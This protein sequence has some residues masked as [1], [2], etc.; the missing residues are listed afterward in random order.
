MLLNGTWRQEEREYDTLAGNHIWL[1]SGGVAH[2]QGVGMLL[3]RGWASNI[4][5][6][7]A[8]GPRLGFLDLDANGN[9]LRIIVAYMPHSGY[10]DTVVQKM[11]DSLSKSVSD[12]R[13]RGREIYIAGDWNAE[14]AGLTVDVLGSVGKY[15]N[16]EE[17]HRGKWLKRW[18]AEEGMFLV[19]T[20]FKKRLGQ[21][22]DATCKHKRFVK[23]L[24]TCKYVNMDSDHRAVYIDI[25]LHSVRRKKKLKKLSRENGFEIMTSP[26]CTSRR[27]TC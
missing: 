6:W 9:K 27:W 4:L 7:R 1:G 19:N 15:G 18:A 2:K 13:Q 20:F 5:R 11:Y 12:A 25:I 23:K 3:H 22:M 17:N 14:A 26:S 21:N 8:L 16:P 10:A 24:A